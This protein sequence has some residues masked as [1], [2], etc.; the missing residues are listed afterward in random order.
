MKLNYKQFGTGQPL[1]ILHGL[2]GSLDNWQTLARQFGDFFSVYILDQRNHGQS[3]H[4]HEWD[5]QIMAEDLNEFFEDHSLNNAILLGHSMGG[6]TAMQFAIKHPEKLQKLI[7]AD[8]A[9]KEYVPHHQKIIESLSA[10]NFNQI[11]SRNEAEEQLNKHISDFG[12]RQFLLKNLYWKDLENKKLGWRFNLE[13]I[14]EKINEV[15]KGIPEN[16]HCDIPTL[17]IRGAKSDYITDDDLE[18]ISAIFSDVKL[19]TIDNAGHW[20]HAEQPERF[21]E[22]VL[23]FASA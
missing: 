16:A 7:I 13:V 10:I 15:N 2:F 4:S 17:F 18:L 12:T 3:G 23:N 8:I 5:Y 22:I 9:P 19:E 14:A 11:T 1:V 20:L 6:K 21:K